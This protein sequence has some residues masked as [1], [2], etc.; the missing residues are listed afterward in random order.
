MQNT[1]LQF[2]ANIQRARQQGEMALIVEKVTPQIDVSD[3]FR[4]QYVFA[5]S[6]LDHL[7]HEMVRIGMTEITE[8]KRVETEQFSKFQISL[9]SALSIQRDIPF[10]QT[11][12][13]IVQEKHSWLSFQHPDRIADAMRLIYSGKLWENIAMELN[14]D[15]KHLKDRLRLIVERRNKIAHEADM[16]P[17]NQGFLWPITDRMTKETIDFIEQIG[18]AIYKTVA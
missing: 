7:V 8:R 6:A 11:L 13:Q 14:S 10:A 1:L 17:A 16:D 4:S 3:L 15:A 18:E 9:S 2:R 5:V 12:N